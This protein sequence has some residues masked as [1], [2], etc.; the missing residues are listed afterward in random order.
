MFGLNRSQSIT[1]PFSCPPA[2]KVASS[3]YVW[4]RIDK[5]KLPAQGSN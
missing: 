4:N 3:E 1:G 5:K 2:Y